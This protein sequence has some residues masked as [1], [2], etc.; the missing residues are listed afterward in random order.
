MVKVQA[1][2]TARKRLAIAG[3]TLRRRRRPSKPR[4]SSDKMARTA[5]NQGL[6]LICIKGCAAFLQIFAPFGP[7][8]LPCQ[9]MG[10]KRWRTRLLRKKQ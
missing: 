7:V 5:V 10:L 2:G 8:F 4:Q 1:I 9:I 6:S 3:A